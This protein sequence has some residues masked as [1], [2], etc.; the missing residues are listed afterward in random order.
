M[1]EQ[2][3]GAPTPSS[4]TPPKRGDS[5]KD[6][7]RFTFFALLIIVPFR[8]F[9]AQ[10][11]VVS[12]ASM[13]P[14][15]KDGDYLI[16]DQLTPR[17]EELSRGEV[18]IFKYPLDPSRSFIK[19]V[20]GLPG[21]TLDIQS[22]VVHIKNSMHPEGLTLAEPYV[23]HGQ[24]STLTVTLTSDEYFVM[25]D[26]RAGSLDSRIWGALNKK[27]IIGHPIIRLLPLPKIGLL[28]GNYDI[29]ETQEKK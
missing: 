23:V 22:G 25:G 26:N 17:F 2:N 18:L 21:E 9:V 28:P 11:Y 6:I 16:V 20:I 4:A 24:E 13:D 8:M 15:F 5:F 1:N 3:E 27:F 14:T 12:G 10:P 29:Y 19:R 7:A